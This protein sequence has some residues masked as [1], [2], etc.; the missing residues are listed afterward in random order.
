M[1][2]DLGADVGLFCRVKRRSPGLEVVGMVNV[3][4]LSRAEQRLLELTFI[5]DCGLRL[6]MVDLRG[7]ILDPGLRTTA[8]RRPRL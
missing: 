5:E 3:A 8:G 4:T 7:T 6:E 2:E 1:A